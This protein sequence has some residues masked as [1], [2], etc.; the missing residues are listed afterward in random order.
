MGSFDST[1]GISGLP[2]SAGDPVRFMLLTENPYEK[3]RV[4]YDMHD[5]WFPR[6]FPIRARYDDYG[7]VEEYDMNAST[8]L[9]M[10]GF[11]VDLIQRGWGDT[12]SHDIPTSKTMTFDELRMALQEG[13][14]IVR[15]G[16]HLMGSKES[17]RLKVP[18]GIPTRERITKAIKSAGLPLSTK[19][20]EKGYLVDRLSF[21]EIRVRYE[22]AEGAEIFNSPEPL[23]SLQKHLLGYATMVTC[24]TGNSQRPEL[25]VRPL[26]TSRLV[27]IRG[28]SRKPLR[29]KPL[30]IR[31]DVWE[32]LLSLSYNEPKSQVTYTIEDFYKLIQTSWEETLKAIQL[33]SS[34]QGTL[35]A[36]YNLWISSE[37]FLTEFFSSSPI[38]FAMSVSSHWLIMAHWAGANQ[39]N[40]KDL[41]EFLKAAAEYAFVHLVL[42]SSTRMSWHPSTC[43]GF[44]TL[45]Q[46]TQVLNVFLKVAEKISTQEEANS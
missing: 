5:E 18:N 25:L 19:C 10:E 33:K 36:R 12:P 43:V 7:S 27:R 1:C 46:Y 14:V 2:I 24:P 22:G 15:S 34:S 29:V 16:A 37:D 31:E 23:S 45:N 17:T 3:N 8:R 21:G 40:P 13:R 38:P 11:K 26:P 35:F 28:K 42:S 32:Q 44:G 6:T 4:H 20:Y 9:W 39:V 41:Q 30:M